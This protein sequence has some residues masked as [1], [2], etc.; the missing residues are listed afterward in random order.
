MD[1]A[2]TARKIASKFP[3][4][5]YPLIPVSKAVDRYKK[6]GLHGRVEAN[7]RLFCTEQQQQD[8]RYMRRLRRDIW[9]SVIRYNCAPVEY[10][11][12]D[13]PR[14]NHAGRQSF[15]TGWEKR[16][17]TKRIKEENPEK[18][19]FF[20]KYK[21]YLAYKKYFH[22]D[23]ILVNEHSP[24]EEFFSFAAAHPRF[25]VKPFFSGG[26]DGVHFENVSMTPSV[27]LLAKLRRSPV[28]LEEPIVQS[29][30]I[31]R[32]HPSSV[33]TLRLATAVKDGQAHLLFS[34]LRLGRGGSVVDNGASGGILCPIDLDTGLVIGPGQTETGYVFLLH[35]DSGLQIVGFHIPRWEEAKALALELAL[36]SPT[37]RY[38]GWD[39][40]LTPDGWV[41]VEGNRG[42]SFMGTQ[43][44]AR[45]GIRKQL[46][47]YFDL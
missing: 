32:F 44:L 41:M 1:M 10:F 8:A 30:E 34:F 33:N 23:V 28:V 19:L 35:P 20:G 15:V 25:I 18:E 27:E 17:L 47:A 2:S 4:L 24:E 13:F 12:F 22:R 21:T 9:Y 46:S 43:F 40:A 38:V 36:V 42:G 31:A 5:A 6:F 39:L 29:E 11:L 16:A 45:R 7:I 3:P 37:Q 14:L 26:G